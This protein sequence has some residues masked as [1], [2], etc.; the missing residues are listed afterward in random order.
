MGIFSSTESGAVDLDDVEQREF[1]RPF[2]STKAASNGGYGV[3]KAID[4]I[5]DLPKGDMAAMVD[6]V[7][8]TLESM[9][10]N[11]QTIV[12]DAEQKEDRVSQRISFLKKEIDDLSG[13]IKTYGDEIKFCK[14]ELGEVTA[15]KR[16]LQ[17]E[18]MMPDKAQTNLDLSEE[19]L[20]EMALIGEES[21]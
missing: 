21:D 20:D 5:R 4:L 7:I 12:D 13:R 19:S 11:I 9:N 14:T 10:I 17:S 3:D 16:L 2:Q 6:V 8:H 15:I 1:E 18:D